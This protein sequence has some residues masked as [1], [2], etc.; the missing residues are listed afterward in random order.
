LS[1]RVE[2]KSRVAEATPQ[3]PA[4]G[5]RARTRAIAALLLAGCLAVLAIAMWLAPDP[6]GYGTAEQLGTGPCG[7]LVMTGLPC[8]TCGMTTAFAHTVRGQWVRAFL[9][10]PGGFVL[11]LGAMGAAVLSVWVLL[12]GRWPGVALRYVTPYRLFLALLVLLLGA[13]AFTIF[14]GLARGT[15]PYVPALGPT[16]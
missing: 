6:R 1:E 5:S 9:A 10:Q 16:R 13:W 7:V 2:P 4:A 14:S 12:R 3:A 8:P 11:A 15:L